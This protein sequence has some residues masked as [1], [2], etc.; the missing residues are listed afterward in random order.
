M[1]EQNS[2]ILLTLHSAFFAIGFIG[3]I[4]I[5]TVHFLDW[6]KTHDINPCDL[7]INSIVCSNLFLQ[8]I[9]VSNQFLYELFKKVYSQ[10]W[11]I[12]SFIVIMSSFSF[13]SLWCSTCLCFYYCVKIVS[14][15]GTLFYKLKA[16]IATM[17]PWLLVVCFALSWAVALPSYWDLY[18]DIPASAYNISLLLNRTSVISFN[19]KSRCHCLFQMYILVTSLA[20]II[21]SSSAVAIITSLCKHM[22]K[23]ARNNDGHGS[24]KINSHLSAAKTVTFLLILYLAFYGALNTIYNDPT[25]A[26]NLYF[27]LCFLAVSVFPTINAIILISGNRKLMNFVKELLGIKSTDGITEVTVTSQ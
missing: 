19:V 10:S 20:F 18:I 13:S 6:L 12:K 9:V 27:S 14:F 4:F 3:N 11:I 15:K 24:G 23:M 1:V 17:V 7:I 5:L 26:G 21:I 25:A 16:N 8:G 2:M 22:R